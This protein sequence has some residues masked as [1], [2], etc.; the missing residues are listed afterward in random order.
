M[1]VF[2]VEEVQCKTE[3]QGLRK[4]YIPCFNGFRFSKN[5]KTFTC[6]SFNSEQAAWNFINRKFLKTKNLPKR[7]F[8]WVC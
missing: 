1:E 2:T 5:E 7:H 8:T 4:F 3:L 6:M